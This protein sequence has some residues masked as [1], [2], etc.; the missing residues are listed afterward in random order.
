LTIS[1]SAL[2][3]HLDLVPH[4]VWATHRPQLKDTIQYENLSNWKCLCFTKYSSCF[5]EIR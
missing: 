3:Q 1:E 4:A 5:L 2:F